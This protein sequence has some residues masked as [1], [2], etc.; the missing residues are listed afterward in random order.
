MN[1]D[2][3]ET[4]ALLDELHRRYDHSAFVGQRTANEDDFHERMSMKGQERIVQ[5]LA[6]SLAIRCDQRLAQRTERSDY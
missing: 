5:G 4:E 3:I 2:L 6:M 1:L